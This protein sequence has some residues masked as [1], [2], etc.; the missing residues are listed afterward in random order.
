MEIIAHGP[1]RSELKRTPQSLEGESLEDFCT[2]TINVFRENRDHT[3]PRIEI[4]V[5]FREEI[6]V[7]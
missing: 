4:C 7:A 6:Q 1:D 2:R 5:G 3:V